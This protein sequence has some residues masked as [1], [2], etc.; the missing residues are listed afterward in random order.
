MEAFFQQGPVLGNP[1]AADPL[2]QAFLRWRLPADLQETLAPG[3]L[4]F[5]RRIV[6]E[7]QELGPQA[8]SHPPRLIPYSPW[9]E[10]IDQI[11]VS[12]AWQRLQDI[13]AREG[14]VAIG[15]ERAEGAFSRLHQF[16]RLYMFHPDAAWFTCPLAMTDGAARA[17]ELHGDDALKDRALAHLLSRDPA[18]FWTAGQWMTERGGG[19]DVG[20]GTETT[21][22]K[23]GGEYLLHGDK[24]FTSATTSP[25]AL[26]LARIEGAP[27]GGSGL[28]LFFVELFD[29]TGRLRNIR[30]NRLKDKLGTHALP[31]AELSLQ[32]TPARLVGDK[33]HG[34]RKMSSLF[35]LTRIHNSVYAVSYMRRALALAK[36]YASKRKAFG[37][38]LAELPAH[39]ETLSEMQVEWEG[40]FH[41]TFHLT[42]LLGREET[43]ES[44]EGE[45]ALLRL[46]TPVA[47]LF[48]AKR[49]VS[50]VAEAME[51]FGGAGYVE[52]T[53]LPALMRDTLVLPIWEGTTNVLAMDVLRAMEKEGAFEPFADD[54]AAR[55]RKVKGDALS[56]S[57]RRVRKAL[58]TL[59][60]GRRRM[61]GFESEFAE[62]I[63]RP[64]AYG[65][66]RT[67]IGSLL[68]EFAS[69]MANEG[70]PAPDPNQ[71][72]SAAV[73]VR[74]CR[75][76]L[77]SLPDADSVHRRVSS[78]ILKE[79]P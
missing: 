12:G 41:L 1:F 28:S 18:E 52:D 51:C 29:E 3:L 74:W 38:P 67:Y 69:W 47:K 30:I 79:K 35:N 7:V 23:H 17:L 9:G 42:L 70:G 25:V 49:A 44:A 77:V 20:H 10:R 63:A 34:I 19:S 62:A 46:L 31:T 40:C 26:T 24:W 22:K 68:L 56:E 15:Y 13:A 75:E 2:L 59:Q 71:L 33:A 55:L 21:A 78:D 76:P 16:S 54:V 61:D 37:K 66:A 5:G 58:E 36:D 4:A 14:L 27:A 72:R 8:E 39:A 57:V 60:E 45:A 11:E 48:T 73:A 43:G 6:D 65:L 53:G 32:G 64:F 50:G